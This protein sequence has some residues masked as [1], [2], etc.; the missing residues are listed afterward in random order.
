MNSMVTEIVD[1]SCNYIGPL[2]QALTTVDEA[3]PVEAG[4]AYLKE[5]TK[6]GRASCRERV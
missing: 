4:L 3:R 1:F 6:I 2:Y 5:I